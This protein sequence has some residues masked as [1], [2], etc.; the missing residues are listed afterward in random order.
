MRG[1]LNKSIVLFA[2]SFLLGTLVQSIAPIAADDAKVLPKNR[3]RLQLLTSYSYASSKFDSNG[4]NVSLG[5]A[6]SVSLTPAFMSMLKPQAGAL[7]KAMNNAQP[8]LADNMAVA[9]IGSNI[10]SSVIAN[11]VAAEYGLTDRLSV[12]LIVPVVY[13]SVDVQTTSTPSP[14]FE[15]FVQ[16][17]P[18]A[19]PLKPALQQLKSQ[20]SLAAINQSLRSDLGYSAGLDSWSGLGLGDIEFGAKYKYVDLHP[21]RMT[22]KG[23]VRAPTGR[24]DDPD[25]LF[26]LGFGDGQWD[27]GFYH[28]VDYSPLSKLYLTLET[29][30][31][32]QLPDT[33][34]FRV[35]VVDGIEISPVKTRLDRDLGDIMEV[36][37]EAN[38]G[39]TR[40]LTFSPK[41]RYRHKFKD[42]YGGPQGL[43][44]NLIEADTQETLHEGTFTLGYSS[45]P[46]VRAGQAKVPVD[47]SVFYKQRFAAENMS[48]A[49]TGGVQFKT[50]F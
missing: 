28:Y 42:D 13:G 6:Y 11:V 31:T 39:I 35:P 1:K 21:I 34:S 12:G 44:M 19:H 15:G 49:R 32:V 36:G 4:S 22:V 17:L 10:D 7:V 27:L 40:L 48:D 2:L 33:R 3:W 5:D 9:E 26:D 45:L 23:G 38:Y 8:G 14:E 30:Y 41:Y 29:G 47:V 16:A 20:A 50:Y 46:L 24:T 37:L 18:S 25:V 43:S